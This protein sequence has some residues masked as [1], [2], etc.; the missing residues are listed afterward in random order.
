M[1]K[2]DPCK[3]ISLT[4]NVT[5]TI[6]NDSPEFKEKCK[7]IEDGTEC[8]IVEPQSVRFVKHDRLFRLRDFNPDIECKGALESECLK[9]EVLLPPSMKQELAVSISRQTGSGQLRQISL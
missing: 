5:K 3:T 6:E 4:V 2:A 7:G 8:T 9:I 1:V